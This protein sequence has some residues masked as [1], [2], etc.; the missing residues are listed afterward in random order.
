MKKYYPNIVTIPKSISDALQEIIDYLWEDERQHFI[1]SPPKTRD[2]H[3][4]NHLST[5]KSWL[6]GGDEDVE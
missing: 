6:E 1:E 2:G 4:F 3:I 5:V